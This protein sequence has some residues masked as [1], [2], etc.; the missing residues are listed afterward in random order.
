MFRKHAEKEEADYTC[1]INVTNEKA[2]KSCSQLGFSTP[3][4]VIGITNET[5][6]TVDFSK[7]ENVIGLVHLN[8]ERT[9]E[10][11]RG[12]STQ[13]AHTIKD[14]VNAIVVHGKVRHIMIYECGETNEAAGISYGLQHVL[15]GTK[16]ARRKVNELCYRRIL[17]SYGIRV[18]L[19]GEGSNAPESETK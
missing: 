5:S 11:S 16:A 12:M 19:K 3:T 1:R 8:I 13:D 2:A 10:E 4:L 17:E 9:E 6:R 18:T 15:N 7:T 14:V